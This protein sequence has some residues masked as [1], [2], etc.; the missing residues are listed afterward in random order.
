MEEYNI[1]HDLS[2]MIWIEFRKAARSKMPLWTIIGSV[3][4]PL[5]FGFVIYIA[6]HPEFSEKLGLLT[7]KANLMAYG[8]MDWAAY[9]ALLGQIIAAGGLLLFIMILSWVFGREFVDGTLKDLLAV[10]IQRSSIIVAKFIVAAVVSVG[11]TIVIIAVGLMMGIVSNLSGGSPDVILRG[12]LLVAITAL[13]VIIVVM[14][15]A[16]FASIGRGYLLPI[17]VAVLILIIT[18]LVA[19]IGFG[20]YFPWAVPGLYATGKTPLTAASYL[21]VV[22]TG[23]IGMLATYMWWRYA[24][25][26]H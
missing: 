25:Q 2:D 6:R 19:I 9:L 26:S 18:N 8:A 15:F 11:L 17:G 7:A 5:G 22:A 24:D 12:S 1:M 16:L 3:F 4:I 13:M 14:P 10:P 23:L 20:E 21:I